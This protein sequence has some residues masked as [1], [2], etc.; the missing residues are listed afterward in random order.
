MIH[1]M[2]LSEPWYTLVKTNKKTIEARIYDE[3]RKL[4]KVN[5]TIKFSDV[6]GKN[7]FSKKIKN[8]KKFNS[9]EKALK[10]GKLKNILPGINTY[11]NGIELYHSIA[12]YKKKEKINGV[13]LIF[14]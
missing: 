9:F 5:D 4:L 6:N 7:V 10:Y 1:K 2:K 11:K 12:D 14:F 8:L 13:L 3:K